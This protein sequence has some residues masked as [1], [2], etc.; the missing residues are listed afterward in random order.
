MNSAQ[1]YWELSIMAEL[2]TDMKKG[3]AWSFDV[4]FRLLTAEINS[5]DHIC[6][7]LLVHLIFVW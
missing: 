6:H 3:A 2:A 4:F 7:S 1:D 5:V